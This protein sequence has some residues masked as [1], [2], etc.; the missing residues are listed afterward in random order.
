RQECFRKYDNPNYSYR[1]HS[2]FLRNGARYNFLFKLRIDDYKGWARG[3]KAAGYA[4]D[5][6][7]P[8]KLI[9]LI[10]KYKLYRFDHQAV[11][12]YKELKDRPEAEEVQEKQLDIYTVKKGDTLYNISKRFGI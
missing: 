4:T 6:R 9:N 2:L 8:R 11:D 1:D 7:Y 3:L 5:P 10:Q 12:S